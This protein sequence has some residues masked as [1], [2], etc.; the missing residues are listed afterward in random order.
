MILLVIAA[1]PALGETF[2]YSDSW[3][4]QGI[5]V[6]REGSGGLELSF[7][8]NEWELGSLDLDG[9][10]L[11]TIQLPGVFL[12]N[13][14]GAPDLPGLSQFI[15][16]P[17]GA[18]ATVRILDYRTEV[19]AEIDLAPAPILP[20]DTDDGPMVYEKNSTIFGN[21]A[22]YPADPVKLAEL[23]EVRGVDATIL[24]ITPFQY[25]PVRRELLVYRDIRVEVTFSGG[26]RFGEDRLRSR[27]FDP[28]LQD[29]FINAASLPEVD[30]ARDGGNRTP[31]FEYVIITPQIPGFIAWADSLREF[32]CEQGIR[33]GVFTVNEV[34]GN[35]IGAIE[36]FINDAY[37]NWDIP[38]V[39]VLLLGD[40][41]DGATGIVSP[42]YDS[43]CV[44]DN[45]FAD[46]NGN[47]M[48]DV[49]L[50]RMT[51][52][53]PTHL[54]TFVGKALDY[55]RQPPTDP[56]FYNPIIAGGWQTERWFILCNEVIYGFMANELGMDP[57]REYAIYSGSPG[58]VWSTNQNTNMILNYF[59]PT[60]LGYLPQTPAHLTDWG[61]NATRLNNDI[62]AGSFLLQHRD[63]GSESG[64]GEP[65][66]QTS[67][68]SGL[69]NEELTFVLSIN[70]LTG[71]YNYSGEC[72]AEAFHRHAQGALGLIAASEV[73]YSF[74]ND[75]YVW[76]M[77]DNMWPSF[78]PSYGSPGDHK[79]LPAFANAAGKYY[80]QASNWPYNTNNK[81]VTYHLFHH[82]G[83]AF[84][85]VYSAVPQDLT[86]YHDDAL[87]SGVDFYTVTADEGALI[88]LSV[89]G[90]YLG[91]ATG[92][93][94][95]VTISIPSQLP[96]QDLIVTV[97]KQNFYRYR[98]VVPIIPPAGPYVIYSGLTLNDSA[99]N[100]DGRLDFTETAT[101]S[102]ELHNVGL[103]TSV[104]ASAVI[105]SEDPW[106]TILDDN[107][108]YG[109]IPADG[110]VTRDDAFQISVAAD[111]PNDHMILF[112]LTATDG[113]STYTSMFS[114]MA[115]APVLEL[116][117]FVVINDDDDDNILDPGETGDLVVTL[118]NAGGSLV[119]GVNMSLFSENPNVTLLSS[120]G[121]IPS[122]AAGESGSLTFGV[123]AD[124]ETPIG[125]VA[126]FHLDVT[127]VDYTFYADFGL[128]V[129]LSIE[130]FE[131]GYLVEYPWELSGDADWA[132]S[133]EN[134]F[135][136]VYCAKSGVITHNQSTEMSVTVA[137]LA[138]GMITFNY[139]VSSESGYDYLRFL[140][141][142]AEQAAW[143]GD[144]GWSE[145]VF[146]VEPGNR[147]FT[148]K[149][150]KDGSVD[151]GSD[152]GW[153][154]YII[155]PS[156]GDPPRP[157]C[158]ITPDSFE[159]SLQPPNIA[160]ETVLIENSGEGELDYH[161]AVSLGERKATTVPV[162][163]AKKGAPD[164]R[165]GQPAS[166]GSGGPD[167]FGYTWIDSDDPNGPVYDWVEINGIG[168]DM[169]GGDDSNLGPFDL[170]FE[171]SYYGVPFSSIRV[172]TNGWLSFTS[173][174]TDYTNQGIPLTDEPNN[175]LAP[176]W[177]DMDVVSGGH[178][179]YYA[180]AANQRFIVEWDAVQHYP[181]GNPETF[182]VILSADHS[183]VYQYKTVDIDNGCTIGIENGEGTDGLQVVFNAPYLHD[184]MAILFASEPLPEPWLRASPMAGT[185][186][187]MSVGELELT[188]NPIDVQEGDYY[189]LVSIVTN[190]PNNLLVEIPVT[191]H[192]NSIISAT[193]DEGLPTA[194][195]LGNA[196]PNPFNPTTTIAYAVPRSGHVTLRIFDVAGRLVRT[197][198]E[199]DATAGHHTVV[200]N[201]RDHGD[202]QVAS[203][204]YY[205]RLSA[206]GFNDTR[207][208]VL[209][210]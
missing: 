41:G 156:I 99:G 108:A 124:P 31:D 186:V 44:S 61:G 1:T 196:Y 80:L 65:D 32:R 182:Q 151:G 70:C 149:Y 19:H 96:G 53:N 175:L 202:R 67:H 189:G 79:L 114:V 83:D 115:Y 2:N 102:V 158:T 157:E 9:R 126:P 3:G 45:I 38:P 134:P 22:Y 142:G 208:M 148:W 136:G 51:A 76:G 59:G 197:L 4:D 154:D 164:P 52:E 16:V 111:V 127:A 68:L 42:I 133:E 17:E 129:G 90:Q 100:G 77:F 163:K 204:T 88:G 34:G 193:G 146:P 171:F 209:V 119:S 82:H 183:I 57:I 152:C 33:T 113:D 78:D 25:N 26:D 153:I 21:D 58:S 62:N 173:T 192:V 138:P 7:S 187:P 10:T 135:E 117:N 180:D 166:R 43:Y 89:G 122:I 143:D 46:V 8:L 191:L 203:G 128:S 141:D 121:R 104:G 6:M 95:P 71:K 49:I 118:L 168:E 15:A 172:C 18:T 92:T 160:T 130:D 112:E 91:S 23:T 199:G 162:F 86:V 63:H 55:E 170:G 29:M 101:L 97:T 167:A 20:K 64:W 184:E 206:D 190:D 107:E 188:I 140:I 54:E 131:S 35:T 48:P 36:G 174:D 125:E 39:A 169:G 28:I 81:E 14:A 200:W 132:A 13:D 85:S 201:G 109:D 30:Y 24:G 177:D 47:H 98:A 207:K 87:L 145:A 75:T 123:T 69:S 159:M 72:F 11:Q 60:G 116:A 185:V 194:F 198:V 139:K 179:Y 84:T 205:Y 181:S 210:K 150:T 103:E 56:A 5:T 147:T 144:Q 178:I 93:G 161:V 110:F 105:T 137:V 73:S 50:A 40:Y 37:A 12:P 120:S 106:V 66:Y 195:A 27:W 155:F 176:F 165:D 94:G 74:V